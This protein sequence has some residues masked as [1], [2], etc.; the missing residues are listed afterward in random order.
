[1]PQTGAD[2]QYKKRMPQTV[3]RKP[4]KSPDKKKRYGHICIASDSED[5]PN[6]VDAHVS[7]SELT[8]QAV[9]DTHEP[10]ACESTTIIEE[11]QSETVLDSAITP[12]MQEEFPLISECCTAV[13]K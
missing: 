4:H 10:A 6:T 7:V 9:E 13:Q 11:L 2:A 1:M 5:E 8:L 12:D 3:S